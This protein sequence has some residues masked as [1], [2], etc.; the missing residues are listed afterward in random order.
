MDGLF[1]ARQLS[2]DFQLAPLSIT[3]VIAS[4]GASMQPRAVLKNR[5]AEKT[6]QISPV[7]GVSRLLAGQKFLYNARALLQGK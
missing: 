4:A 6:S 5:G 1:R 2:L 3:H 7:C